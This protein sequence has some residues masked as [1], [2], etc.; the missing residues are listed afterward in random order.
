MAATAAQAFSMLL[1]VTR[2]RGSGPP[3]RR[4]RITAAPERRASASRCENTAGSMAVPGSASPITSETIAIVLAVNWPGQE[5]TVG[6]HSC[7]IAIRVLS[8]TVPAYRPP[9]ASYALT[10]LE[11]R[12]SNW[13]GSMA[14]PY[15]NT[16][17]QFSRT[18][19]IMMAGRVLSQPAKPTSAS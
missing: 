2:S 9:T 5:P 3:S 17:G 12:P 1:R 19:A 18:I 16:D 14:P 15:M 7:S 4:I 13:P 6:E 10:V 8:L 11:G